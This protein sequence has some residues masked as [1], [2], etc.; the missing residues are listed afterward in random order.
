MKPFNHI[1]AKT[2]EEAGVLLKNDGARLVAG[3]TDL[4]GILKDRI[5]PS[6][7]ILSLILRRSQ[8]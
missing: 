2:T 6:T 3:G 1:D 7:R 4:L 5:L 8:N